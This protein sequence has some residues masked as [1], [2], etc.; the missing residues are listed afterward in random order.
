MV[1]K[2]VMYSMFFLFLLSSVLAYTPD[3]GHNIDSVGMNTI[4]GSTYNSATDWFNLLTSAGRLTGGEITLNSGT[5]INVSAGTGLIRIADDDLSDVKFF[6]WSELN[7][8]SVPTDSVVYIGID[9]NSGSPILVNKSTDTWDYDTQFPLGSVINQKDDL[10]IKND[11]WWVGDGLTNVIERF[12]SEGV[13]RDEKVGGLTLSYTGTR[14]PTLSAGVVW[15]L[16]NEF[17]ID[18]K[19]C[20][21]SDTFNAF[22]RDGA[23]GWTRETGLTQWNNTHYDDNSGTLAEMDNNKY[24]NIWVFVEIDSANNGTLM[25]IYP[26]NQYVSSAEA[27]AEEVPSF[28]S[29]WYDHG[30]LVGRILFKKE[31]DAPVE[32]Q[33]AFVTQFTPAQATDHGNLAGL[34]DDDHTIYVLADGTRALTGQLTGTS[35]VFT[36]SIK[37]VGINTTGV[38]QIGDITDNEAIELTA[39]DKICFDGDTCNDY[40]VSASGVM[41]IG[42]NTEITGTLAMGDTLTFDEGIGEAVVINSTD[43]ICLDGSTCNYGMYFNGTHVVTGYIG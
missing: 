21:G 29:N 27:E 3:V 1:K 41:T 30:I 28:P 5:T 37:S 26:Q 15:S 43:K 7:N 32:V 11:Y 33:S 4:S 23:S 25:L 31:V 12:Q 38:I 6:D 34:T 36:G 14:N 40:V 8:I 16:L 10:Y 42:G 22:Y 9:Y 13:I 24:A 17:T 39:E 20:S 19:D 2:Y 18:A 35:A